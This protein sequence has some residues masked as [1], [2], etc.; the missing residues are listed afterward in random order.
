MAR[1]TI[2]EQSSA[3]ET[4]FSTNTN[5]FSNF[6]KFDKLPVL[7]GSDNYRRWAGSWQIAFDSMVILDAVDENLQTFVIDHPTAKETWGKLQQRFDRKTPSSTISLLKNITNLSLQ[8]GESISDFLI[9]FNDT[10]NRLRNRSSSAKTPLAQ[11]FR[12]LTHSDDAKGAF[13]LY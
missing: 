1:N 11:T 13:L 2:P 12:D 5:S 9:V 6:V 3:S 4:P 10:W 8:E 7:T